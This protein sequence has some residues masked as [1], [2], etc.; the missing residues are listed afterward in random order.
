MAEKN[1]EI[2]IQHQA[3]MSQC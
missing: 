1:D 3:A 2:L